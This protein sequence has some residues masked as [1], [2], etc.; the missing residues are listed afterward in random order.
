MKK[1]DFRVKRTDSSIR[2][3]SDFG[4]FRNQ[5]EQRRKRETRSKLVIMA[6]GIILLTVLILFI[7]QA[8]PVAPDNPANELKYENVELKL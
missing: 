3:K 8:Q 6:I 7:S 2:S 5:Y 1:I 4:R